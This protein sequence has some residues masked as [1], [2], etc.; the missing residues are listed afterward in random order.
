MNVSNFLSLRSYFP[1]LIFV[2]VISPPFSSSLTSGLSIL[3]LLIL[4]YISFSVLFCFVTQNIF[5]F[6]ISFLNFLS[7]YFVVLFRF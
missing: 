3:L 2:V 7:I 4:T 6:M 5:I 1:L